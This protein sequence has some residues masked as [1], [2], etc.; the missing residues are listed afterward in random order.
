MDSTS[1]LQTTFSSNSLEQ[2]IHLQIFSVLVTCLV[3]VNPLAVVAVVSLEGL[4]G[5]VLILVMVLVM[6]EAVLLGMLYKYYYMLCGCVCCMY[7]FT[8]DLL[9]LWLTFKLALAGV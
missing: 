1:H 7:A 5:S 6:V 2:V 9:V 4:E 3:V 8:I